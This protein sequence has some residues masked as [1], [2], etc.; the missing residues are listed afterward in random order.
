MCQAGNYVEFRNQL[1]CAIDDHSVRLGDSQHFPHQHLRNQQKLT[2]SASGS[3]ASRSLASLLFSLT[4]LLLF[5]VL[6]NEGSE[7]FSAF[8]QPIWADSGEEHSVL[9]GFQNLKPT[10][11][12]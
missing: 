4:N 12:V 7:L 6:G 11:K 1:R 9:Q 8:G 10:H 5:F 3:A 2:G